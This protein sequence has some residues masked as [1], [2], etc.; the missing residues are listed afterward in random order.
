[1]S[2]VPKREYAC[3]QEYIDFNKILE[4]VKNRR[5]KRK[6]KH[7][8]ELQIFFCDKVYEIMMRQKGYF[9]ELLEEKKELQTRI[10][11]L[12]NE[13]NMLEVKVC[14]LKQKLMQKGVSSRSLEACQVNAS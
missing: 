6:E 5:G 9:K 7:A 13:L 11:S 10:R 12:E 1:M 14:T 2:F 4:R 3:R 8:R